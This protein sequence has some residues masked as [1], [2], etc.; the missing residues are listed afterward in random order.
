MGEA[1][2]AAPHAYSL[3]L[4]PPEGS[5][6]S[7]R[8]AGLIKV[9]AERFKGPKFAPHVTLLGNA[10]KGDEEAVREAAQ[11][12]ASAIE[13]FDVTVPAG[14]AAYENT[15]NQ[16]L[17]LFVEQN[18]GLLGANAL[19][20]ERLQGAPAGESSFAPPSRRP[21]LSLMYG[22]HSEEE[23]AE[24]AAFVGSE[25]RWATEGFGFRAE[26][27]HL[28]AS[29]PGGF[30]SETV[31]EWQWVASFPFGAAAAEDKGACKDS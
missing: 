10:P 17:L 1:N 29:A 2:A 23:R 13:P 11:Q 18:P 24:A 3:W 8:L 31:E 7:D 5:E 6:L 4:C 27:V 30:N 16:N 9:L 28:W 21:H 20:R 14:K 25:A 15:W 26:A 22:E 12:L 19:A